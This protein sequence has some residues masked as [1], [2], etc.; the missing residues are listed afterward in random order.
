MDT[1]NRFR[2]RASKDCRMVEKVINV[3][4]NPNYF[5]APDRVDNGG[6]RRVVEAENK[7]LEQFDVKSVAYI[8]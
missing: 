1:G 6:I 2:N 3:F 8:E 5:N 7:Y 4:I